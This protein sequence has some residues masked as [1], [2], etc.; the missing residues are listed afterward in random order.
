MKRVSISSIFLFIISHLLIIF[1][2]GQTY[3]DSTRQWFGFRPPNCKCHSEN[4]K[5]VEMHEPF[6]I[7]DCSLCH[8][9]SVSK[10]EMKKMVNK[11]NK[12]EIANE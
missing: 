1:P 5:M 2:T 9:K 6:G 3:S 8:Q 11:D 7:K 4:I 10:Q 12:M